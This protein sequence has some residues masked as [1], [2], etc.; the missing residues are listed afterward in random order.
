MILLSMKMNVLILVVL[1]FQYKL[2]NCFLKRKVIVKLFW[3][4]KSY[5]LLYVIKYLTLDFLVHFLL[6]CLRIGE[7]LKDVHLRTC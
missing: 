6:L 1:Q 7:L 5:V 2:S 3:L 4:V